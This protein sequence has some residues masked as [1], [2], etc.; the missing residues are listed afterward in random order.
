MGA[1]RPKQFLD[2]HGKPILARTI[3]AL[4]ESPQIKGIVVVVPPADVDATRKLLAPHLPED[5]PVRWVAGGKQR[6]D[7]VRNGLMALPEACDWVVIHD[8]VRPFVSPEL[9]ARTMEA[10]RKTGAAI[11]AL[12]SSDT[13]KRVRQGLVLETLPREEIWLVQ[14]PQVFRKNILLEAHDKCRVD[15]WQATDDA[16]L[17]ERLGI[18][19]GIAHGE[20]DNKKI[21]TLEDLDWAR[22]FFDRPA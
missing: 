7:S 16:T 17:V 9:L 1:S 20:A 21:T 22:W 11:C 5:S 12:P 4:L 3:E 15:G 10:A 19:V 2:L 6:Q 18:S 13:V 8:G 14:T